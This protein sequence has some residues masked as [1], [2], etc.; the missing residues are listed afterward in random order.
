M[1]PKMTWRRLTLLCEAVRRITRFANGK[2][3]GHWCGLGCK[4]TYAPVTK[5]GWMRS[6]RNQHER[7]LQ[8]MVLTEEGKKIVQKMLDAG[9]S[10]EH[11]E[12]GFKSCE[13]SDV[14]SSK[15]SEVYEHNEKTIRQLFTDP[16]RFLA[17]RALTGTNTLPDL[18]V[19]ALKQLAPG[20]TKHAG[21]NSKTIWA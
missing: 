17:K 5:A 6:V 20:G 11:L 21:K 2:P 16:L 15:L 8:W 4:S 9:L 1:R 3:D 12:I 10:Y 19:E 14:G 7:Q 13:L 18:D